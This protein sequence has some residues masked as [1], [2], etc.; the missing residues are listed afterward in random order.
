MAELARPL[1]AHRCGAR[2]RRRSS[3][4][5]SSRLTTGRFRDSA[6]DRLPRCDCSPS[7]TCT[8][9]S[10]RP[11]GW[12]RRRR[13]PT[14]WS[15]R[16]TSPR[17]TTA[18]SSTIDALAAID[19]PTV[20]VPGNNE[21]EDALREAA[22]AWP[23]ATVLHGEGDRDRGRAVLRP[24]RR[25]TDHA[26]GLE[27]RSLRRRGRRVAGRLPARTRCWSS[28][29]R[30]SGTSTAPAPA[31]AWA[32]P[33][34]SR[35]SRP[36]G[37]G[38][39][40]AGTSTRAGA[41]SHGSDRRG[42]STSGPPGPGST[43][44]RPRSSPAA[45]SVRP[46]TPSQD[47]DATGTPSRLLRRAPP[48]G[49]AFVVALLRL[50]PLAG[51][52]RP[53][54]GG[55][56]ET[57]VRSRRSGADNYACRLAMTAPPRGRP[58]ARPASGGARGAGRGRAPPAGRALGRA[59]RRRALPALRPGR[60]GRRRGA[61]RRAARGGRGAR[62]RR[63][64]RGL[65]R[66][67]VRDRGNARRVPRA[68]GG[69]RGLRGAGRRRRRRVR[70]DGPRGADGDALSVG[71]RWRFCSNVDELRLA[72]GRLRRPRRRGAAPARERAPGHPPRADARRRGRGDRHL[73]GLR[74]ARDRQPRHRRRGARRARGALGLADHR[75][76]A[77][78][79]P[80]LRVPAVRAA[81]GGDRRGRPRD[82]ARGARRSGGARRRQDP[83]P[84]HPQARRAR[85]DPVAASPAPRPP[86][87]PR[88]S[89]LYASTRR[90]VGRRRSTAAEIP[91]ELRAGLRLA[92][93]HAVEAAAAAVD[94]AYVARRR[95]RDL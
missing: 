79:R 48:R 29:P 57:T 15:A 60:P 52:L 59:G 73:D 13:T 33:R 6:P 80:A 49:D 50:L 44:E 58:R 12:S 87:A 32:V 51:S 75:R 72:D 18:S 61:A 53:S 46:P 5:P 65:V 71:G 67:R 86:C 16:A 27:L 2:R 89:L 70:A 9:T 7:R 94:A 21:T 23:A 41:P 37:R 43:S 34:S 77:R 92:S 64:G 69:P 11:R 38:S 31:T 40:C 26:L 68:R 54:Q 47:E 1:R 83:D 4:R 91:V 22:A 36:S 55:G 63:R 39:R 84:E 95:Q 76:A 17:S 42:S 88:A 35:R 93:T 25:G 24:R 28:T 10:A 74:P 85:R 30:R 78:A 8:A 45:D 90:G 56:R 66:G 82:R 62:R 3:S 81:G 19:A 20:L 14:S